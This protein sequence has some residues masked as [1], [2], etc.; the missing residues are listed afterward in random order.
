[1][2]CL[3]IICYA[4]PVPRVLVSWIGHADLRAVKETPTDGVGPVAQA[5]D[6]ARFDAAILLT[7]HDAAVLT[8]FGGSSSV[9]VRLRSTCSGSNSPVPRSSGKSTSRPFGHA[10]RQ[11]PW[12]R[13]MR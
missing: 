1:M 7:D 9:Q 6:S 13:A 10:S 8:T 12:H 2:F 5:I 3:Q 4:G 11:S